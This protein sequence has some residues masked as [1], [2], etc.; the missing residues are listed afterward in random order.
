MTNKE[1]IKQIINM[2]KFIL[3]VDDDEIKTSTIE[4]IIEMLE[5]I[6]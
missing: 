1:K 5:E 2:L 6:Y 4:S 3:E